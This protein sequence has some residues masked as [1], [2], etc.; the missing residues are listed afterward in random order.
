MENKVTIIV[1][2]NGIEYREDS[3]NNNIETLSQ[4]DIRI[5]NMIDRLIENIGL[6]E[7]NH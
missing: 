1:V 4:L 3:E 5:G 2:R 6:K 7:N